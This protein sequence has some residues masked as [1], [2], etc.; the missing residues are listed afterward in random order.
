M[1]CSACSKGH[2]HHAEAFRLLCVYDSMHDLSS[3]SLLLGNG[4]R[5]MQVAI[6]WCHSLLI[7]RIASAGPSLFIHVGM[8]YAKEF[9]ASV[10]VSSMVMR[11]AYACGFSAP[12]TV[13]VVAIAVVQHEQMSY[14]HVLGYLIACPNHGDVGELLHQLLPTRM[15]GVVAV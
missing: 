11:R 10:V 6:A 15:G 12:T 5:I 7:D 1:E 2:L 8:P 13:L 4:H 14:A 3:Y 9:Y